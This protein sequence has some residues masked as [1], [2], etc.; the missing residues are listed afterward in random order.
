[1]HLLLLTA[2]HLSAVHVHVSA[3]IDWCRGGRRS[4]GGDGHEDLLD[5]HFDDF[6]GGGDEACADD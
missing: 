6:G 3:H 5:D 1:M 2:L 4:A